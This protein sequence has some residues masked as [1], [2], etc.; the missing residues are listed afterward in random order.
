MSS[1]S[2]GEQL[3]SFNNLIRIN[4]Q[5]ITNKLDY[6]LIYLLW[7][8]ITN[9]VY[10]WMKETEKKDFTSTIDIDIENYI[11]EHDRH[12]GHD[13]KFSLKNLPDLKQELKRKML[14]LQCVLL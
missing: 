11:Q 10:L 1:F 9:K 4:N 8:L 5:H 3:M 2:E 12:D 7:Y 6:L 14:L 13:G